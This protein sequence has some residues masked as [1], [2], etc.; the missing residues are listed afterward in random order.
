MQTAAGLASDPQRVQKVFA[1]GWPEQVFNLQGQ[2]PNWEAFQQVYGQY[3]PR[4]EYRQGNITGEEMFKIVHYMGNTV[5]GLD[6]WRIHELKLLGF[7]AWTQR[8]RVVAVQCLEGK[9][10]ASYKQVSP[11]I[12]PNKR[13]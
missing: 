10:P 12:M 13:Y 11:P 1:D 2:K 4:A 8:E 3:V 7:A 9:V 6:G 5:P